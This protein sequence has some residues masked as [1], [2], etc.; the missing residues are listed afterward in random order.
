MK[1]KSILLSL[2]LF[3]LFTFAE[4]SE[5]TLEKIMS[6]PSWI[7]AA[8]SSAAWLA[9]SD[10]VVFQ[11]ETETA[12]ENLM[13]VNL[14]SLS[15]S[16]VPIETLHLNH[17]DELVFNR[18]KTL[19][20]YVFEGNLFTVDIAIN[21]V[22]QLTFSSSIENEP[23]FLNDNR[24]LF[25]RDFSAY[26]FD[27]NS[28][29]E[30][31]LVKLSFE[32]K[33]EAPKIKDD[34]IST[35]Q[36]K[37]IKFVA[38][39]HRDEV[40][41]FNYSSMI[42][43]KNKSVFSQEYF[44]S[45]ED[46]LV[47]VSISPRGDKMIVV[48]AKKK[49]WR[50]DG[51]IMPN[52]IGDDGR[53]HAEKVRSR[54]ADAEPNQQTFWYV[55]LIDR[56]Q[57]Q[58]TISNLDDFD[59]DVLK[60]V[61]T[62]NAKALGKKYKSEK[63][64]RTVN[65][66]IDW[67]WEQSPIQWQ[68]SGDNVAIMLEAWDNKDRWIATVDFDKS[69]L[70]Q[71]H[72]LHDDAWINYTFN[73]FG[74]LP[75]QNK[76]YFLS[77]QN[78]YSHIYTKSIS[79]KKVRQVTDGKFEV[80]SLKVNSDGSS[81][82]FRA[83]VNHPGDYQIYRVATDSKKQSK[84]EAL[85]SMLGNNEFSISP[86]ET[87][88]LITHST[89]TRPNELFL[90]DLTNNNQVTQLTQT[91]SKEFADYNWQ[92][93]KIVAVPSSNQ[94]QPIYSKV[95]YPKNYDPAKSYKAVIFNHGAG[96]TQNSDYGFSYYFREFMFHNFL[97]QQGYVVMDMDYRASKGYGRDWRTAIYRQMGTPEIEDL[98]DGVNWLEENVSVDRQRV[99]TYGGSY[100]GFMTFMALFTAPDLF[101]AGAALRP[102]SDWAHYNDGYT[103][104][105][106][107][108]PTNDLLAYQRSSP[109]YFAEGLN[110]PLLI[111]APMVDNNVFFVDVVRLVQRLIELEKENFET[112]IYPVEPHGFVQPSSWLD[113]YRRI[114]KL[115]ETHL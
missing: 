37:L 99:G 43:Q 91:V 51:D 13:K 30:K 3:P 114:F 92:A 90:V 32:K 98:K 96:Y 76:L 83:N 100:G 50:S 65:L 34:V 81:F 28:K 38:N 26:V 56:K 102:V 39:E 47:D 20:A 113:E 107:N 36:H 109:I 77:E 44:F 22:T 67:S 101:Q 45:P 95:Y 105:I 18:N 54:V 6:D 87:K 74:W 72:Q 40:E 115:F 8:P 110:K 82:F 86:D 84:P 49:N 75:N 108:R 97:T 21:K 57:S 41:R 73:D 29:T 31:E 35:E 64:D 24:L 53:I 12:I 69:K 66:I 23:M 61:K 7:G 63:Q 111:N 1:N 94:E 55:D 60:S 89:L 16:K 79:S 58:I 104:N 5:L 88:L 62:E 71:Q 11:Q 4:S 85:T 27:L 15:Q 106:L 14:S 25:W 70:K 78:G 42:N 52:Y 68:Q 46:R 103:S 9:T 48:T 80:S 17:Q 112:A 2:L 19:A 10:S 93:P 59:K 33:P